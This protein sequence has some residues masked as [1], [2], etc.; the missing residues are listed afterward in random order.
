MDGEA[1]FPEAGAVQRHDARVGAEEGGLERGILEIERVS[2][3]VL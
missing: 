1:E 3:V 2:V